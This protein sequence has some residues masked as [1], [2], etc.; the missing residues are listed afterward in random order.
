MSDPQPHGTGTRRITAGDLAA[1]LPG[2]RLSGDP[3]TPIR[4]VTNDSRSVRPGDLFAC[5]PGLKEDGHRYIP[6]ALARGAACLLVQR[7]MAAAGAALLQVANTRRALGDA[8]A[9]FHGQ[10]SR[11]LRVLAVTGTNGKTTTA[12]LIQAV[13]Q[14]NGRPAGLIGTVHNLVG[15][16]PQPARRT[17]PDSP[18]L[19]ELLAAMV[20]AGDTHAVLEASSH[21]L[22]LERLRC[23]E[24]D[25][26]VFTNLA[27]D[28]FDFHRD[29]A[30]YLA[31]KARLFKDLGADARKTGPKTA[32]LNADDPAWPRLAAATRAQVW[33]F[34]RAPDAT[35]R[36]LHTSAGLEGARATLECRGE[37]IR[38]NL[39]L[40][41]RFSLHNAVG[42][43]T[44]CL[45][46]GLAPQAIADALAKVALV[47]GRHER[48]PSDRGFTVLV[49]F[50][51][52]PAALAEILELARS[53]GGRVAVVFGCEGGKDPGKRPLM[54]AVAGRNAD[55]VLFTSDNLF[56]EPYR[57]IAAAVEQGLRRE[58]APYRLIP[59]RREA[60]REALAWAQPGDVVVVAGKGHET[61]QIIGDRRIP[62]DDRQVV[63]RILERL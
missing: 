10:P 49:D 32:V 24:V 60:I 31:A 37:R 25:T 57:D 59:D 26:A 47:P 58:R 55:L 1:A 34:G 28:H 39:Q 50:A 30:A 11:C 61:H 35:V 46:E 43:L 22:A 15:S 12:H 14:A 63:R 20:A 18:E 41:G 6:E 17:T 62:F 52:N 4:G 2:S 27:R 16:R 45:A 53:A 33:T 42:A 9:W 36:L 13:L 8:A 19:Q 40:P 38:L 21:A 51:H 56:W 3:A 48:I 54:G 44:A 7:P 23:C 5:I 29:R